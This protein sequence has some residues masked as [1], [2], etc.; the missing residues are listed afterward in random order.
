MKRMLSYF[1]IFLLLTFFSAAQAQISNK[2]KS[3]LIDLY[4]YTDGDSWVNSWS[5][6]TPV[7]QW[8]GVHIENNHVVR[9]ELPKNNL[10]GNLPYTLKKLENLEVLNLAFNKITGLLPST[11]TQLENLKTLKLEMND[12]K[13]DLSWD[14]S[15]WSKLEELTLF[16]NFLDGSLPET[17]G[18]KVFEKIPNCKP[19]SKM[20]VY[21]LCYATWAIWPKMP[22]KP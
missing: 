19:K 22:A 6:K 11:L 2:E 3:A 20:P 10:Q 18:L 7:E 4:K 1:T 14:F 5:L 12:I 9:I 15:N 16:N 13:G 21:Q 8:Y 17:I